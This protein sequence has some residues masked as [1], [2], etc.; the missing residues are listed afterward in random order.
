M[1]ELQLGT[2]ADRRVIQCPCTSPNPWATTCGKVIKQREKDNQN[3]PRCSGCK[4]PWLSIAEKPGICV[5][6][7]N[8]AARKRFNLPPLEAIS[9][10]KEGNASTRKPKNGGGKIDQQVKSSPSPF[11]NVT[12]GLGGG[13]FTN[14]KSGAPA[15]TVPLTS[16]FITAETQVEP[17]SQP[18][19]KAKPK[20]KPKPNQNKG[21]GKGQT[22]T[23]DNRLLS[24]MEKVMA[25]LRSQFK[26]L[27]D[28]ATIPDD[29]QKALGGFLSSQG[30]ELK[31]KAAIETKHTLESLAAHRSLV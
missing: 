4:H 23:V 28:S 10:N 9:N 7:R 31:P 27:S 6:F 24:P 3:P 14:P 25:G 18:K 20:S 2:V 5:Y 16:P 15:W 8:N 29:L 17:K 13:W 12:M 21:N 30:V 22:K 1:T 19:A 11:T 26:G